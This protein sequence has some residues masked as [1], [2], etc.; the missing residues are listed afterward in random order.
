MSL[1][2]NLSISFFLSITSFG[3]I[4]YLEARVF[5]SEEALNFDK[6]EKKL[7]F[8]QQAA[9]LGTFQKTWSSALP[10][11][12][13]SCG[14]ESSESGEVELILAIKSSAVNWDRRAAIRASW[15][16]QTLFP[17]RRA[18]LVFLV[19]RDMQQ[20]QLQAQ[21]QD[22][23]LLLLS[24]EAAQYGDLL[25]GDFLD[26]FR[27]LAQKDNLFLTWF[28]T[29]SNSRFIFKGDDDIF[30][31]R[32]LLNELIDLYEDK[33]D[34]EILIGSILRTG[35]PVRD[36]QSKYFISE[37]EYPAKR[38]PPY[39]SG[40]GFLMTRKTALTLLPQFRK[41]QPISVD[42]AFIGIAMDSLGMS[43]K[44]RNN[45]GFKSW[46]ER[47]S[48]S[49]LCDLLKLYTF[50]RV[51]SDE[52]LSIWGRITDVQEVANQC[53]FSEIPRDLLNPYV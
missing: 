21:E 35:E 26:T 53:T 36:S 31:N 45:R 13:P 11:I 29:C 18:Q 14:G 22:A 33:V 9:E 3:I 2:L 38:F 4:R 51:S 23:D 46:G 10:L 27:N 43:G 48:P 39:P 50:H 37:E 19:G 40:G 28:A 15:G 41:M 49:L 12:S 5:H 44:L 32:Y 7:L 30:L 25:I 20:E 47:R 16:N 52:L 34:S 6:F 24:Q 1:L 17:T 8:V 42:D